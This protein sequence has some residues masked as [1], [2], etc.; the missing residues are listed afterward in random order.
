MNRVRRH[1]SERSTYR[2]DA[3]VVGHHQAADSVG[4]GQ[5]RGLPGQSHL[6]AGGTPGNE[7][8]Q[9]TL[10]DPL[11][12][13]VHLQQSQSR[14]VWILAKCVKTFGI[15]KNKDP[16]RSHLC[17]VDLALDDVKDGDVAVARLPLSSCGHHHVLGLQEPPHHVQHCGFP[18][19]S[20]LRH[21]VFTDTRVNIL[22]TFSILNIYC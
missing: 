11:E 14:Q 16:L 8:G 19:T 17:G 7:A 10:P 9:F 20:N 5:V 3:G 13:F 22:G 2:G 1:S 4:R 6:D 12:A 15:S 18:H 21:S